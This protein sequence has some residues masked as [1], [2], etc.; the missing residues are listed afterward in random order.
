M[1][2]SSQETAGMLSLQIAGG[3]PPILHVNLRLLAPHPSYTHVQPIWSPKHDPDGA[4]SGHTHF[5]GT[6]SHV[7]P[8]QISS[9]QNVPSIDALPG[10]VW[11]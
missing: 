10:C 6:H 8:L 4:T 7:P 2:A 1:P 5:F 3:V 9:L 11:Q